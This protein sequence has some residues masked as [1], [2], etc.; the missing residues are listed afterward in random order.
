[1]TASSRRPGPALWGLVAWGLAVAG[2]IA[3][4]W[5]PRARVDASAPVEQEF[6][7]PEVLATV[8]EYRSGRLGWALLALALTV[9]VPLVAAS[10]PS[11]RRSV[12]APTRLALSRLPEAAREPVRGGIVGV[13]VLVA[14]S[15]STVPIAFGLGH[16]RETAWG[17]RSAGPVDWLRD[18]GLAVGVELL[19]AFVV[20]ALFVVVVR[21]WPD[22]WHLRL[23]PIATA[24]TAVLV[25]LHPLVIQPLFLATEPL[26]AGE[27][28]DELD[29]VLARA[30]V[31]AEIL[32]GDASRRTSKVNAFVTGLGPTRQVVLWDNL[33]DQPP[34]QVAAVVAHELAHREH[35]DLPRGVLLTATGLLPFGLVM[36]G[37][38]GSRTR[39]RVLPAGGPGTAGSVLVLAVVAAV[40]QVVATPFAMAA[41]RQA[42]AAADER[43]IELVADAESL[44]RTFRGFVVRDLSSPTHPLVS[45]LFFGTHPAIAERLRAAVTQAQAEGWSVPSLEELRADEAG[46]RHDRIAP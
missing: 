36:R 3:T 30:D 41:S 34:E 32:V 7:A 26:P 23:V 16:V 44:V 10:V 29:A 33:L 20:G 19:V 11:L 28:R 43:G 17:F 40:A 9:L 31:E 27:L 2:V 12:L 22:D 1:M 35:G 8:A 25:L 4:V 37:V 6:F 18:W 42:E 38:L 39:R 15:L 14:V 45:D 13:I 24:L 46:Q 21:R 5:R